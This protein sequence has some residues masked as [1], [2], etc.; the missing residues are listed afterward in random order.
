MHIPF[1]F[2]IDYEKLK[3]P[4]YLWVFHKFVDFCTKNNFPII[5]QEEYFKS[6]EFYNNATNFMARDYE[7]SVPDEDTLISMLKYQITF[8][9]TKSILSMYE[10]TEK[11]WLDLLKNRNEV[12]ENIIESKIKMIQKNYANKKIESILTWVWLPSLKVVCDKL[13]ITLIQLELSAIRKENYNTILG[14]FTFDNKYCTKK[15]EEEYPKFKTITSEIFLY[16]RPTILTM[17][18]KTINIDYLKSYFDSPKYNFGLDLGMPNECFFNT[19]SK[20]SHDEINEKLKSLASKNEIL[21]R[22]HPHASKAIKGSKKFIIDDSRNSIEWILKCRRIVSSVS[23][24][25]FE[26]MLLGKTSYVLSDS[27]P[28]HYKAVKSLS[29]LEDEVVD[30][31]F[32]NYLIFCYF[33]P[34]QLMFDKEYIDFRLTNPSL[35]E[36]Y[37]K[38]QEFIFKNI[39]WTKQEPVTQKWLLEHFHKL[40]KQ[41]VKEILDYKYDSKQNDLENKLEVSYRENE[42]IKS[43]LEIKV[44]ELKEKEE[45]KSL[46]EAKINELVEKEEKLKNLEKTYNDALNLIEKQNQEIKNMQNSKSWKITKPL[47]MLSEKISK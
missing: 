21:A 42:E 41:K 5:A 19:Y 25:G 33:A 4:K 9:E 43:L 31:S 39:N 47:R 27:M 13:K 16:D 38:N 23:N 17:F 10:D 12:L 36:I 29:A 3:Y 22:G 32:L 7:F 30:L 1:V 46:L 2:G 34:Y 26:A 44:N 14:Y 11:C 18:L 20:Y 8:E 40:D 37:I 24:I 45:I 35:E 15:I 28:F 6:P